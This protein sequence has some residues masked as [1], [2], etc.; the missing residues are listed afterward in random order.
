MSSRKSLISSNSSASSNHN[1]TLTK[2]PLSESDSSQGYYHR[3]H[4]IILPIPSP[5]SEEDSDSSQGYH[6]RL[7]NLVPA[8]LPPSS[9]SENSDS[10][11]GYHRRLNAFIG[12]LS[13]SSENISESA[14]ESSF[15]LDQD[16]FHFK[17]GVAP[18]EDALEEEN[19]H[20]EEGL[21]CSIL[22]KK[23]IS[24]MPFISL[25]YHHG[26]EMVCFRRRSF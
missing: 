25:L 6:Q 22:Q 10:S 15:H 19:I 18:Q 7:G 16:S 8:T 11:G 17:E 1:I 23:E 20:Q 14:S 4:D 2:A 26:I 3:L 21:N 5:S 12:S 24:S 13:S 9:S